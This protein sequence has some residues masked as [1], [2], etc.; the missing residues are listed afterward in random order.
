M[1]QNKRRKV[2]IAGAGFGGFWAART[3]ANHNVDVTVV[4]R[5]NYHTF[6]TAEGNARVNVLPTCRWTDARIYTSSVISLQ[7][8]RG[9]DA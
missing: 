6:L 9:E 3:L 2:V 1:D 4:D 5:N 7:S 8:E